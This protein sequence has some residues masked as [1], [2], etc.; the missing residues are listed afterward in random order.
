MTLTLEDEIDISRGEMLVRPDNQPCV[1]RHF[2][3]MFVW[4][5]EEPMDSGKHFYLKQTTNTTRA[6]VDSICYQVDVNTMERREAGGFKLNEIGR[7]RITT[8]KPL[9]FDAYATNKATGA[10]I[11]IDPV[12]NNTSAVGMIIAPVDEKDT[13]TERLPELNLPKLGIGPEHYEAVE[14]AVKDLERQGL[15]VNIIKD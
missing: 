4:M 5:D 14:R 3:A 13:G 10:F 11:L 9:F 15:A 7:V 12:T 1:G 6:T 8:A 2:E